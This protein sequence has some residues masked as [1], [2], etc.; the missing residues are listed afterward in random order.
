M[1][2]QSRIFILLFLIT[3]FIVFSIN[4][5]LKPADIA[6]EG[7]IASLDVQDT[8]EVYFDDYGVPNIF[9]S[10]DA[11]MFKVAGYIGA[12]DRLFQILLL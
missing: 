2:K 4:S 9:A 3:G 6:Y 1:G 12:R 8:V 7:E 11:D 10:N 5:F